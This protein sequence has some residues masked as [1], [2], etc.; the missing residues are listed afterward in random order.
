VPF[1][2][3]K[4]AYGVLY[5]ITFKFNG[6]HQVLVLHIYILPHLVLFKLSLASIESKKRPF[7]L[8]ILTFLHLSASCLRQ[9]LLTLCVAALKLVAPLT[10]PACRLISNEFLPCL[11]H[12][13]LIF[14]YSC[15]CFFFRGL[16]PRQLIAIAI[17]ASTIS[18]T[19]TSP[20]RGSSSFPASRLRALR[21]KAGVFP[22]GR[23]RLCVSGGSREIR[24][25]YP[26]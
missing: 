19:N 20:P 22:G 21:A 25:L 11:T 7:Y 8:N 10:P 3:K 15:L 24:L 5:L 12:A 9:T 26:G 18:T 13:N 6:E 14:N 1:I 2:Y 16:A 23:A 4:P 17:P